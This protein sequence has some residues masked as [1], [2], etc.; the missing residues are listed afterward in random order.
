MKMGE[1]EPPLVLRAFAVI[2]GA[3][4][5]ALVGS[6]GGAVLGGGVAAVTYL[7]S[8]EPVRRGEDDYDFSSFTYAGIV[9]IASWIGA[10]VGLLVFAGLL[11]RRQPRP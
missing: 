7:S 4:A 2:M 6:L 1:K 11:S 9:L 8:P 5:S 3:V 10:F